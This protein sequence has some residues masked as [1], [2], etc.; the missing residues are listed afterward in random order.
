MVGRHGCD[1]ISIASKNETPSDANASTCRVVTPV[2][3]AGNQA[4]EENLSLPFDDELPF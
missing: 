1:W 4:R 3:S 2:L